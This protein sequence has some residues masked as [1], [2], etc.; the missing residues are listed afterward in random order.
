MREQKP[1]LS[2]KQWGVGLV[3]LMMVNRTLIPTERN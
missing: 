1:G 3:Q 2:L